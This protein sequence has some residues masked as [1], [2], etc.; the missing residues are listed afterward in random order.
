M[1]LTL[2]LAGLERTLNALLAR[3]PAA[4]GRLAR[5]AGHRILLRLERP[6]LVLAVHFHPHGL[7]LLR[8]DDAAE[9]DYDAVVELDAETAG[10][11]LGGASIERLMFQGKLAVR[12]RIHLLEAT[13]D[14]LL[15]LDLDWEGEL[16]RWLGDTPAHS[17][18]EGLRGITR[19]GLRTRDE[20][21]ADVAEYV[22]EE[23]RLLPGR[24]QLAVLRDH[25][26]ELEVATDRLEA[27]L[28]RLHR[29]LVDG[30]PRP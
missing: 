17:L 6:S 5:L 13:R 14:L 27:R 1:S 11:L 29:R 12:G 2:L 3:D 22:F 8:P 15:D 10:E 18:A 28:A 20:F 4:P 19:W 26:T 24:H 30:E 25:L 23:A 16:A 7:D 21:R 9:A